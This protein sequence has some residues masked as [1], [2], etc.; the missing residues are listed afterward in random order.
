MQA[1]FEFLFKYPPSPF[2]GG[3][4]RLR[5]PV[6]HLWWFSALW[7]PCPSRRSSPTPRPGATPGPW[8]VIVLDH[9]YSMGYGDR[10]E[11]ATSEAR[12]LGSGFD[13]SD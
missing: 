9:S 8:T 3:R 5:V 2:S 4:F 13:A 11:R 12:R 1:I 7:L 10:W 6:A